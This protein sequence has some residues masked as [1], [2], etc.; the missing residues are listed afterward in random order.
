MNKKRLTAII[1]S[2]VII[3]S[4]VAV[5]VLAV[6]SETVASS[7]DVSDAEE[8]VNTEFDAMADVKQPIYYI[9]ENNYITVNSLSY[10]DE[11]N[12]ILDCTVKTL[13]VYSVVSPE[14]NRF[15]STSVKKANGTMFKSALDFKQEFQ[16]EL[17]KLIKSA[18]EVT[19]ETE[20]V[21]Y[22]TKEGFVVYA[23]DDV[24]NT[25][26]GGVV[27]VAEEIGEITTYHDSVGEHK[28]ESGNV[29]KGFIQCIKPSYSSKKPDISGTLGKFW[30]NLKEDFHKNFI[31]HDR[32]KTIFEGLWSTLKLTFFAL[33]IGIAIGFLVAFIRCTCLKLTNPWTGLKILDFICSI[34]LT[35]IRGT[36]VVVQIMIIYFVIF[37]PVGVDKFIAAVICFGLNSGAYVA[38]IV[39][40]GILS[41]DDGQTEAGRS[42]GFTYMQ[43]MWSI[44]FPQAFKNVLPA[45]ANEFVVLLKETSIA[46]YIGLEDL[47]Y[48]GNAIRAATYTAFMPLVTV[49]IIYLIVVLAF[50]KLVNILE[51]RLRN[52]ER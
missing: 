47:M 32:W 13:D 18:S 1:V 40:G 24:V 44:V 30:N 42:L 2:A 17:E 21:L 27:D 43:T 7:I 52:S 38:E 33:L 37:M 16:P 34:Y 6:R 10:G 14:Y 5:V 45:L 23:T 50:S 26:F 8:F 20:I 11:K 35:V 3:I 15:L 41:I 25:V 49:G 36:P 4:L 51:R 29:N 46:F 22:D 12:V 39:R 48:A 19:Y 31:E 9:A 28:I